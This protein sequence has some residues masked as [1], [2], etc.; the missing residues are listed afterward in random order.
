[1]FNE[2]FQDIF[3]S[4]KRLLW[5]QVDNGI[6]PD[7]LLYFFFQIFSEILRKRYHEFTIN[8]LR[9]MKSFLS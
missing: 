7:R 6:Q 3:W 5:Q 9:Q 1:M 2:Q 8:W 4:V